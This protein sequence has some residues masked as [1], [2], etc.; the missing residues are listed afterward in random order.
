MAAGIGIELLTEGQYR[1]LQKTGSFDAKTSSWVKTP[2]DIRKLG[3]ASFVI[4]ATTLFSC[5]TTVRNLIMAVG[6]SLACSGSKFCM[7]S[8]A[9]DA[10][11]W[12]RNP[13]GQAR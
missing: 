2:S 13:S 4:A 1:E 5:I 8:H 3:G 10:I 12:I 7:S 9:E 11:A 6:R